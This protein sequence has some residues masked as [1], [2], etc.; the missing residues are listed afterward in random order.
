MK[1]HLVPDGAIVLGIDAST[2]SDLARAWAVAEA[3]RSG[4]PLHL[5]HALEWLEVAPLDLDDDLDITAQLEVDRLAQTTPSLDVTAQSST[6]SAARALV[7][8]SDRAELVVVGAQ[9]RG[10]LAAALL[11]SVSRQV[12]SHARCPVV[13][14]STQEEAE[15]KGPEPARVVVGLDASSTSLPALAWAFD[16]A[17]SRTTGLT[18]VHCWRPPPPGGQFAGSNWAQVWQDVEQLD[19]D[20]VTAELREWS[21]KLPEVDVRHEF[22][23]GHPVSALVAASAGAELLV[24]ASR[25]RGGFSGLLLGSVSHG[26]L[27]KAHCPVVGVPVRPQAD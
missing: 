11:G 6:G 8:A 15:D 23:R 10:Q 27:G 18:A 5:L 2:G 17:Q 16:A 1:N 12:A 19:R 25:G 22:T 14:V 4:R 13:V 3:R 7:D 20:L 26:V 9:G 21:D 24:V